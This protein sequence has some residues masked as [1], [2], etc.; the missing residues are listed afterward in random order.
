VT[1]AP[2][3]LS[4]SLLG[5]ALRLADPGALP[6]LLVPLVVLA[7]GIV[8][9]ARR[10]AALARAAGPLAPQV[11]PGASRSRPAARLGASA[12]G[13][14]LLA[15]ALARPQCGTRAELSRSYG[16]DL[17]VVLDAS[18]SM[19]ADDV[20]PDRLARA[21]LEVASLLETLA[22][23]RVA[24][25]AFAG[26]AL[27]SCPL[28]T[29]TSAAKLFLRAVDPDELRQGTALA[30]ALA[31]ARELLETSE[32]A[33][34]AKVVLVV[35]DGEDHEGGTASAARAL[36]ESGARIF[37]LAV[38]TPEGAPVPPRRGRAAAGR[39][40]APT[41]RLDE[42][43]LR[44]LASVGRGEVY[45]LSPE[46]GLAA[47][48]AALDRMERTELEGRLVVTYEERY[49]LA[50]FPGFLLLLLGLLLPDG[51]RTPPRREAA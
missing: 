17:V 8:A 21:K 24:L 31:A 49:A 29:D 41:T 26:D 13:L 9:L 40:A 36:A 25:V 44:L 38:G 19:L 22:G 7:L 11:A 3:A 20:K 4:F 27:V 12:L 51:R 48:R 42:T 23:D 47:F 2:P 1:P 15:L 14:A 35:S 46:R 16:V 45:D 5:Y 6:L 37:A 39:E 28:T 33:G 30:E 50:A 10:R 43:T 32:R 34:R 18:R